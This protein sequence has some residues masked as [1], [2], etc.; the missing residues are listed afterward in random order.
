MPE[1]KRPSTT[2]PLY[3]GEDYRRIE[4]LRADLMEAASS[5]V[6]GPRLLS[7]TEPQGAD[8]LRALAEAHDAFVR[9]AEERAAKVVVEALPRRRW[10][11]LEDAHPP[12]MVSKKVTDPDG[13]ERTVEVPHEDDDK[14]FNF[15]TMADDLVPAS[16]PLINPETGEVQFASEQERDTFLDNLSDPHFSAI[17]DAAIR[18]NTEAGGVPKAAASSLVDRI[19]AATLTSRED[20]D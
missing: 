15:K 3:Q 20:S 4:E 10:R 7:D 8:E 1:V 16:L 13:T 5:A 18:L 17:Y 12:R 11:A 19:I 9:E 2:V 14:G 6:V